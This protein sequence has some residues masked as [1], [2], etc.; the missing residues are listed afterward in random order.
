MTDLERRLLAK[1]E[2]MTQ[3][4]IE[5]NVDL[6][7]KLHDLTER[8]NALARQVEGLTSLLHRVVQP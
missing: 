5:D 1:V 6:R 4:R 7:E 3:Q 2:E 8:V